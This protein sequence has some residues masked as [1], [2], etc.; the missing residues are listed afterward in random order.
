MFLPGGFLSGAIL[1]WI[2]LAPSLPLVA[3]LVRK[4][5]LSLPSVLLLVSSLVALITGIFGYLAADTEPKPAILHFMI[6]ID[7]ITAFLLL[8]VHSGW[9][10]LSQ[11][12]LAV[13]LIFS[14]IFLALIL[15]GNDGLALSVL[16]KTGYLALFL[17]ALAIILL[18]MQHIS[19]YI[20]VSPAFWVSAGIFFLYGLL[21]LLLFM[22]PHEDPSRLLSDADFALIYTILHILRFIFFSIAVWLYTPGTKAPGSIRTDADRPKKTPRSPVHRS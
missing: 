4:P 9:Q 10:R 8:W 21:A 22:N 2:L 17:G 3:A 13:G 15:T 14:G 19:E 20:T 18:R 16:V 12:L 6:F 11:V 5:S 1:P 7:A